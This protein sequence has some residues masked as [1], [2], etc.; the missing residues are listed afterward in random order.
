[1]RILQLSD[2]HFPAPL[3][4]LPEPCGSREEYLERLG[5]MLEEVDSDLVV[6]TG[7]LA[8]DVPSDEVYATLRDRFCSAGRPV[9]AIPGN[10][11]VG[12]SL[13]RH[14]PPPRHAAPGPDHSFAATFG[15]HRLLFLDSAPGVVSARSLR[16]LGEQVAGSGSR[17]DL[18]VHHPPLLAGVPFM[19]R[20]YPLENRDEVMAVLERCPDGAAVFCGH[21]H[22]ARD[23]LRG[24]VAVHIAPSTYFQLDPEQE[25]LVIVSHRPAC[26]LIELD[27]DGY[28]TWVREL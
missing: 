5:S 19:D 12:G 3:E 7:D 10:H 21:Y 24:R 1:M 25:E 14:F 18:F 9:V 15:A 4:A 23:V 20:N 28:R 11:D 17:V 22:T 27:R 8:M 13:A 16:W 6:L 2:L 26:R